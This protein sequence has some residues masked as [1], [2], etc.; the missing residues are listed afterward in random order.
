ME[1]RWKDWMERHGYPRGYSAAILASIARRSPIASAP[2]PSILIAAAALREGRGARGGEAFVERDEEG[3]REHVPRA[4]V[5][6]GRGDRW[7]LHL[8]DLAAGQ[9]NA[10]GARPGGDREHRAGGG[11]RGE[12]R[13][14]GG[15]LLLADH[16]RVAGLGQQGVE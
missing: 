7:G 1:M 14:A 3:R 10:R 16:E 6:A 11:G 4:E 9:L 15:A 12:Q 5:V 2:T 8:S 13:R